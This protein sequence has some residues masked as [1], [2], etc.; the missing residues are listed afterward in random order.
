[1]ERGARKGR[2]G[3]GMAMG[4][5][6]LRQ[7]W[8]MYGWESTWI[9]R[10]TSIGMGGGYRQTVEYSMARKK[11]EQEESVIE[12]NRTKKRNIQSHQIQL[13]A[14]F[15]ICDLFAHRYL[16]LLYIKTQ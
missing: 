11:E 2:G 16:I 9:E 1:M 5:H 4:V 6:W 13:K 12:W 7:V 10:H 15:L 3:D 14:S 8:I